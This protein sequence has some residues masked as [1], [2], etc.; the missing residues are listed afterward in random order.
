MFLKK[1]LYALPVLVYVS[2]TN[3]S[4][5]TPP[6]TYF[7]QVK[8]IIQANCITCHQ[9]SGQGMPLFFTSDANIVAN[10]ARIKAAV[11]DPA[12]PMNKHMPLG[13]QLSDADINIIVK[14]F[15]KGGKAND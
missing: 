12:T 2:C 7:P 6:S 9:P 11:A 8:N 5:E 4:V 14:W 10:A 3:K 13:G 15:A 1:C